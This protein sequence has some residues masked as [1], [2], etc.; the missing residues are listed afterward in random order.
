MADSYEKKE[1]QESDAVKQ[2][3]TN[4]ETAQAAKPAAYQSQWQQ[5]LDDTISKINN[6]EK[7][8]YDL[9]GDALYQQ[10]KDRY[11]QQG[12]QAMM[13]TI[14]QTTALTGGYGNSYSQ[15]AGQQAYQSYLQGLNDKVPELYQLALD[16]YTQEGTDLYNRYSMLNAQEG[17]DYD[18][19]RDKVSDYNTDLNTAYNIYANERS[20]DYS[21]YTDDRS[22][23]YNQYV[24]ARNYD[25]QLA[26]DAASDAQWQKEYDEALRQYNLSFLL[27]NGM[28]P[29]EYLE[30]YLNPK[31]EEAT[32]GNIPGYYYKPDDD[33]DDSTKVLPYTLTKNPDTMTTGG[34]YSTNY[35]TKS[36]TGSLHDALID[37]QNMAAN[38]GVTGDTKLADGTIVNSRGETVTYTN[39]TRNATRGETAREIESAYKNGDITY[40]E[41]QALNKLL[42]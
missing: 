14:G 39:G 36:G 42:H 17:Q 37:E 8:N 41:Y 26:R 13:D 16:R 6:R 9:N 30:N 23:D 25:Y 15:A 32:S 5:A 4:L 1:Y 27:A 18:R 21:K 24:D 33:D 19:Y 11:V 20:N 2:A 34:S 12:K 7:F 40:S 10:Y 3:R 35:G 29:D 31:E 28:L 22:F 38:H